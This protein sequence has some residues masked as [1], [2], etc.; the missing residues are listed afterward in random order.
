MK[1]I[2][3][4][5]NDAGQRLDRFL[6]KALPKLPTGK[7]YKYIREKDIKLNGRRCEISDRLKEGD[8]LKLYIPDEFFGRD[9]LPKL[10]EGGI[11]VI[12][13]DENLI[14]VHKPAGLVVHE[15][16]YGSSDTLIARI[17]AYLTE[18]GEYDPATE[19]SFAPALVHRIDRNT[20]GLVICAKNAESL[21]ELNRMIKSREIKKTY[22]CLTVGIPREREGSIKTYLEKDERDNTVYV[23]QKK[24]PASKTAVTNYRVLNTYGELALCE[25]ELVT[26]RTHQIRVHM[27]YIGC[28]LLG[29]GKYGR[30]EPNRRYKAKY[31]ALCANRLMFDLTDKS[32]PLYYLCGREFKSNEPEFIEKYCRCGNSL[33][34]DSQVKNKHT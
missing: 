1:E 26:G 22:L 13:E 25:V 7:M 24:T 17:T 28:P 3:I 29:D 27:A 8:I 20:E 15:D 2:T 18:K 11:N 32:S 6:R 5:K 10:S 23:R 31:Q 9:D 34:F 4:G 12:Y 19:Q 21:R 33:Q 30:N 16:S 14:I